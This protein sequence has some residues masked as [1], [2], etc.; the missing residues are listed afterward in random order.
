MIEQKFTNSSHYLTHVREK[1][2]FIC[3]VKKW[4]SKQKDQRQEYSFCI[5]NKSKHTS[6]LQYHRIFAQKMLQKRAQSLTSTKK[7]IY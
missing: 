4:K 5:Q 3:K 6:T 2:L 7:Q 1:V